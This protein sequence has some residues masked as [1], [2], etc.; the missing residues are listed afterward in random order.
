MREAEW[1]QTQSAGSKRNR[2]SRRFSTIE[3]LTGSNLWPG[4]SCCIA[5][6]QVEA[7][8]RLVGQVVLYIDDVNPL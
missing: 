7:A 8:L 5:R 3:D 4:K 6:Q 1:M 2:H